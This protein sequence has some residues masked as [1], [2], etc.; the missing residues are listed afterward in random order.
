MLRVYNVATKIEARPRWVKKRAPRKL[1]AAH[2][3]IPTSGISLRYPICQPGPGEMLSEQRPIFFPITAA[4][5]VKW[6]ICLLRRTGHARWARMTGSRVGDEKGKVYI[7]ADAPSVYVSRTIRFCFCWLGSH[8]F[9][10]R[11]VCRREKVWIS[12][13]E[14]QRGCKELLIAEYTDRYGD[15][16]EFPCSS[17]ASLYEQC[18]HLGVYPNFCPMSAWICLVSLKPSW[19]F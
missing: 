7:D 5:K 17:S 12:Q 18:D 19:G 14:A 11:W 10:C 6:P 8:S 4:E 9:H 3:Y 15:C 16:E 1:S 13:W 2:T